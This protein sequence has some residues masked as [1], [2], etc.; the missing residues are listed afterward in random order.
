[1]ANGKFVIRHKRDGYGNFI[2][3]DSD[4]QGAPCT[5][6]TNAENLGLPMGE[7]AAY[8]FAL[9]NAGESQIAGDWEFL[10]EWREKSA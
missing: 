7:T 3:F 10:V 5:E 2:S 1:M 6:A 8:A 4:A 9:L